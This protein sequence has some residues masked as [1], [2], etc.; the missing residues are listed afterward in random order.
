MAG[1]FDEDFEWSEKMQKHAEGYY[2]DFWPECEV[3]DVDTYGKD[4]EV[5]KYLDFSGVD[6]MVLRD[7]GLLVHVAQRFRR[8]RDGGEKIDFTIRCKREYSEHLIEY[9]KLL[10]AYKNNCQ[11]PSYYAF[12][13]SKED[14]LENGFENFWIL[15]T[16][17]IVEG[18]VSTE[19]EYKGFWAKGPVDN[20]DGTLFRYIPFNHLDNIVDAI[21]SRW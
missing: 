1:D 18:L 10:E 13:V 7:D 14:G 15:N 2:Q 20:G 11:Y 4:E 6:K 5:A 8:P 19:G 12:G 9:H 16:H 3:L 21:E 17:D